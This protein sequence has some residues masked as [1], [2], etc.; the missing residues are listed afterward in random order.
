MENILKLQI[1][2]NMHVNREKE[3]WKNVYVL[4]Y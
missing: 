3:T 4:E 1:C 2:K